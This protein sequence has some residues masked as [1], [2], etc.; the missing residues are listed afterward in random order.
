MTPV[1]LTVIT[2]FLGSGKTTLIRRMLTLP[3]FGRTA[4][5]VNEFG[6][7][8]LDHHLIESSDEDLVEL[9]TGCLCCALRGDLG[10]AVERLLSRTS[11]GAGLDRIVL[12]TTGL[13]DPAPILHSLLAEPI[14]RTHI[15]PT[16]VVATVDA[17]TGDATLD[18]HAVSRKQAALA[19]LLLLTK[20]DLG[21]SDTTRLEQR[22]RG[23]NRDAR[24]L[25]TVHGDVDPMTLFQV[26]HADHVPVPG[27]P[28]VTHSH[29]HDDI[30]SVSLELDEPLHAVSLTLFLQALAETC[31]ADLLRVKGLVEIVENPDHATVVHGV[32]HVFHPLR[33]LDGWPGGRRGTR[34]VLIGRRLHQAWVAALLATIEE[35]VRGASRQ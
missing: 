19:D 3:E 6:E 7:V 31:G 9:S 5:I 20:T 15:A 21:N 34:L 2:G 14:L 32:Q 17:L 16:R 28:P 27:P 33:W 22:L 8:G 26:P 30:T 13:A 12:E 23:L 35:E 4:I 10:A 18:A 11:G 1:P 24:I 29:G 25:R